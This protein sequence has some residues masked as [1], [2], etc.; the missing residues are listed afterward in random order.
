MQENLFFEKDNGKKGKLSKK[1]EKNDLHH[2]SKREMIHEG[3]NRSQYA[4]LTTV[5]SVG[6]YTQAE[7]FAVYKHNH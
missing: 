2:S 5:Q 4:V 6:S 7:Y 1:K 3:T